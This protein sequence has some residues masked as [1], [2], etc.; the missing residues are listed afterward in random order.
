MEIEESQDQYVRLIFKTPEYEAF[1]ASLQ[2]KTQT[3]FDYVENIIATIYNVP[4]KFIKHLE[5][6]ELYEMRVSIS[7]NEYRSIL[8]A[9]DHDNVIEAKNII[10][11]NAFLKKDTKDYRRQIENAISILNRLENETD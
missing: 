8:F 11:L 1:Y 6:T 10:L 2:P 3:K 4:S 7:T 9:M 5:N